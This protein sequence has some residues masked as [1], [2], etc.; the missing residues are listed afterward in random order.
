MAWCFRTRASVATVLTT[1]PC[2]SRCLG[3]I[4]LDGVWYYYVVSIMS[5][6]VPSL[7]CRQWR[8]SDNSWICVKLTHEGWNFGYLFD[9]LVQEILNSSALAMELRLSCSNPSICYCSETCT[10]M[11]IMVASSMSLQASL[12]PNRRIQNCV[13]SKWIRS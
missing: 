12:V 8:Q 2:V 4:Q 11:L 3:L 10:V 13:H 1:H 6:L 7:R 5:S 9:G